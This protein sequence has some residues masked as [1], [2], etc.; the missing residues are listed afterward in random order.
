MIA[1]PATWVRGSF[2][3]K[4][5]PLGDFD[6]RSALRGRAHLPSPQETPMDSSRRLPPR[7]QAFPLSGIWP[8][9]PAELYCAEVGRAAHRWVASERGG[10]GGSYTRVAG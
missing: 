3:P 7:C 2:R 6:D 1:G 4:S 8:P 10:A 9:A 5:I